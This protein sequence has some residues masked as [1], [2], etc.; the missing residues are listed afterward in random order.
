MK[1]LIVLAV[2]ML[3]PLGAMAQDLKIAYVK[4]NEVFAA[5]PELPEIEKQL[6]ALNEQYQKELQQMSEEYQK[7]YEAYIAEEASLTEN[8]KL[9]RQQELEDMQMKTQNLYQTAQQ[10]VPRKR[11]EL[12]APVQQKIIDAIKA[13]GDEKGYTYILDPSAL[14]YMSNSAVDATPFV[15]AKLGI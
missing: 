5:M 13:V 7:K 8:I 15:R 14:L 2:I 6:A 1:K 9:R 4:T 10:E 3:L 11:D 12:V